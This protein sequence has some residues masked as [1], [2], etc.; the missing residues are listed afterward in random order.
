M[1]ISSEKK[2]IGKIR[3][4]MI[5]EKKL[6]SFCKKLNKKNIKIR[7]VI[8]N[9]WIDKPESSKKHKKKGKNK[10]SNKRKDNI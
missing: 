1:R 10:Y 6:S 5:M 8:I 3:I 4:S 7:S 2:N 9:R